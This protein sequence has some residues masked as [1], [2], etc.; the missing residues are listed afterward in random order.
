MHLLIVDDEVRQVRSLSAIIRRMKPHYTV[1]EAY[2]G[3]TA[4]NVIR[5]QPVHAVITDIRMPNMDG[6]ELIDRI[7][8]VSGDIKIALLSG[9]SEFGY[10]KTAIRMG[11]VDY[12]VK[13]VSYQ[14]IQQVLSRFEELLEKDRQQK[15]LRKTYETELW[16]KAVH[17]LAGREEREEL[18]R[19]PLAPGP[20]LVI[21]AETRRPDEKRDLPALMADALCAVG[22]AIAFADDVQSGRIVALVGYEPGRW[23]KSR[24]LANVSRQ[25]EDGLLPADPSLTAGLS[26]LADRLLDGVRTLYQQALLALEHRFYLEHAPVIFHDRVQPFL[27]AAPGGWPDVDAFVQAVIRGDRLSVSEA[28]RRLLGYDGAVSGLYSD[29]RECKSRAD[30]FL[31]EAAG[32]LRPFI[33]ETDFDAWVSR[34]RLA[35]GAS[36]TRSELRGALIRWAEES[37]RLVRDVQRDKNACIIKDC[38]HFLRQ[39][40]MED[41]TLD[42]TAERYHYNAA[43]FSKLFKEK[44]GKNFSEVLIEIRLEQ[45]GRLLTTTD[46]KVADIARQVG[47]RNSAYFIRMFKRKTGLS[48]NRYR[49]LAGR[50]P[51]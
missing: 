19:S 26:S 37:I 42:K 51:Q 14:N 22:D 15:K 17:G 38:L 5:Q 46:G 36:S 24:F 50:G 30:R 29:P 8:S 13:P 34:H 12:L 4:W 39:H 33:G 25:L 1:T 28:V 23:T 18:G 43:Y 49:Q 2:D 7:R 20:G 9:Y 35:A 10:A 32:R 44:T 40:Y 11:V 41:I 45:A 27:P 31:S 6:L 48:P 3:E 21:V 16:R 47:F